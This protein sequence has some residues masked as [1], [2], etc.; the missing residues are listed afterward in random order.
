VTF[1]KRPATGAE[2]EQFCQI[3]GWEQ[4]RETDHIFWQK[5]LPSGE[6]LQ[7]HR[8]FSANKTFSQ[9]VFGLILRDQLRVSREAFWTALQ[10]GEPVHRPVPVDEAPPTYPGWMIEGLLAQGV[11]EDQ[12]REWTPAEAQT[13][14]EELWAQPR[15]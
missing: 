1:P 2:L 6:V 5:V 14:L 3:D 7:T 12:I 15:E 8:S 10:T 11:T 9:N 13:Q 4:I